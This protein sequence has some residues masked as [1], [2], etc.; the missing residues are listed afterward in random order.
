MVAATD[1]ADLLVRKGMAFRE[2][3]GVVGGLVRT[4]LDSGRALSELDR[5]QLAAHS[6]LL[7][8]DYYEV[9]RE[10]SW[11]DSKLSAGGTAAARLDEQLERA[12]VVLGRAPRRRR[13][14]ALGRGLLRA[15]GARGRPRAGRL[16]AVVDGVGGVIVET[17]SYERDDPAC[18][19]YVGLT[20]RTSTLFGPPGRAYVYL[21]YGIHS[22][23]NAV[24][25]P[26]GTA[27]AVLIRAIEPTR[28]IELMR[29]RRGR[30][31]RARA[32]LR[33]RQAHRRARHRPRPQRRPAR[34]RRRSSSG[35]RSGAWREVEVATGPRIGITKA[36]ELPWRFCAAGSEFLSRPL[37]PVAAAAREAA[38]RAR[39]RRALPDDGAAG[40]ASGVAA[41]SP[42]ASSAGASAAE[43]SSVSGA[44][45]LSVD[46]T[47]PEVSVGS[48]PRGCRGLGVD[49]VRARL[50]L[51]AGLAR[52]L[53]R[54]VGADHREK[55]S[56][57]NV[58]P[59]TGAPPNSVSIGVTV[60]GKPTQTQA[61]TFG[62]APQNQASPLSSVV[63]V[64][65]QVGSPVWARCA[66]A[67]R[68]HGGEDRPRP[69]RRRRGRSPAWRPPC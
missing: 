57:G 34:P 17:E 27:A 35:A 28:G 59:S 55:I 19:A 13:V 62:V 1:V 10:A 48:V 43:L 16:R 56:A 53:D 49:L 6:E 18:H 5:E 38:N 58:P 65:P 33:P 24:C 69:P 39:R 37:S 63:P 68:D 60:S 20:P 22:L 23:L 67:V 41:S 9:L 40:A 25:E 11:L 45:A 54:V 8:D 15:L 29:R 42:P 44:G 50:D 47:S 26:E 12:G 46:S 7:D 36:T 31:E 3:H 51:V 61:V 32:L 21:S 52:R 66:G 30:S 14:S 2:A 4:A 64:L